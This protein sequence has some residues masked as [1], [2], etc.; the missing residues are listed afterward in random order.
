MLAALVGVAVAAAVLLS[1]TPSPAQSVGG[2][3]G[4]GGAGADSAGGGGGGDGQAGNP[5]SM[6]GGGGAPGTRGGG[7]GGGGGPGG[8]AGGNGG[9]VN[10]APPTFTVCAV[11]G[12]TAGNGGSSGTSGSGGGGGGGGNGGANGQSTAG[13]LNNGS[14]IAGANGSDGGVGGDGDVTGDGGGGGGGG[15]GGHG[16]VVTGASDNSNS[17]D[18]SG[19][20]G[21]KGGDGGGD[22]DVDSRGGNGGNGGD[23]GDGVEFTA[24]GASLTNSG[25][26][27]GGA[28]GNGGN[29]GGTA[30]AAD[31]YGGNGGKGGNGGSGVSFTASGGTLTNS[32]VVEG[33][34]GGNGGNGGA[35]TFQSG[36]GGNGGNGGAGAS[37]IESGGTLTNNGGTITGGNGGSG[38][39][40]AAAPNL[41][42]NGGNGGNGGA[43]VAFTA[44]GGTLTNS[45][46]ITGGNGGA[47]GSGATS[48]M[49]V[50]ICNGTDGTVG[51]GGAG[52]SG[53]NLSVLDS[54][55]IVGGLSGDSSTRANAITF[56][57]GLNSLTLAPGYSIIGNVIGTGSDIFA[58]AGS[59]SATFD[60]ANIGPTAQY[61]GFS[62]FV[63]TGASVW[64]LT[65]STTA[66]TPWTINQGTLAV[67]A[68]DNLGDASGALSFGGG[69]LQFLAAFTTNRA[70]TLNAGGGTFDTDGNNDTLAGSITG[71]GGLTK[72]G[73]GILT[74]AG[75]SSYTG[76]TNVNAG[77]LQAAGANLL[78][79]MSAFTVAGGAT[80]DLN[81]FNQTIGSL[82]GAGAVTLG[83]ATL[84]NGGD[85]TSTTYAGA[86]SGSGG[87]TK[88]GT[89]TFVLTGTNGYT[90]ATNINAG[91]LEVDGAITSSSN[92]TVNAGG[93][94]TGTGTVDPST[95]TIASGATFI[96]GTAGTA[97]SSM[98]IAGNLVFQSG[99]TYVVYVNPTTSSFTNVTGTASLA[100][101]VNANFASGSYI[102]KVY[103]ILSAGS[104]T[105]TFGA[106]TTANLP[107]NFTASLNYDTAHAYLDLALSF[108]STTA[109]VYVANA[110]INYFNT[111]GG[112]P[113]KFGTL[114]GSGLT[115]VDGEAA[116]GAERGAFQMMDQ[117]LELI[118]DPF[119]DS[120]SGAGWP[121]GGGGQAMGFA[122]DQQATLPP[123]IAL[124]YAGVLKAPPKQQS[125][126]QRWSAW[127]AGFGGSNTTNGD[128]VVGSNTVTASDYGYA[129]GM[130]YHFSP[131]TVGGFA[132]AGGG[133]NW[134]LAQGLGGGRSDAFQAGVYG[135][136]RSGPLYLAGALAF[137]NNWMTTN[138]I[139]LGDQL[140]ASFNA[141]SYGGRLEAGYRY[142]VP[143][144]SLPSPASGGGLGWGL[145]GITPY[146][147][148]Q[149]QSF[150]TPSYSETDLTGG[151]FGLSY[152]AMSA[153]DTR[154]ELGARFD[155]PT[156]LGAMPLVLRA[157]V[158]WA[159]DWVSNPA[160][161]AVF[162]SLPGASFVVN[163]APVPK[164][165][166]LASVGAVLHMTA[167]L[168]FS[169]K[170]DGEF[171][172]NSQ[173]YAGSGT[174]RY[175]W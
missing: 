90:G 1:P 85:N 28:G 55:T 140:T 134:G 160:L 100:G 110:L 147:A 72:I 51:A 120:R 152:S 37:F 98:T 48:T 171:A 58:L 89:G 74:L 41:S 65:G 56:T 108:T 16:L 50:N 78:A 127:G 143:A 9:A 104:V 34:A 102:S 139:A 88:A 137:A 164:D 4:T 22:N 114:T 13:P 18:I 91:T 32:N 81:S 69:T 109:P 136:T 52:V 117:F 10:C 144:P 12:G 128:P 23:G 30:S 75:A 92:V 80:L 83:S 125:F 155:D 26:A 17:A 3:G 113:M 38:G 94:L 43:G 39:G 27:Q 163:G 158:A 25:T 99:S 61:Q 46:T 115:N 146:A 20:I 8:G 21:G 170:F 112:I 35:A 86:I 151:G 40:G 121:A 24:S 66:V 175:T 60:V 148:V 123:D 172:N 84:T 96:P 73:A 5:G 70:V 103:T 107:S 156:L 19:G 14:A 45:G 42:G 124:A 2:T 130:D 15:A 59:G 153:T 118:L 126:D 97:G 29:G 132:L 133:T 71:S 141:Q 116:T 53:A 122:P 11:S 7:G 159:H 62:T 168:S 82:A 174:L 166:A 169:A 49:C 101:A 36:N 154:S 76:A 142:A 6:G 167:N 145:I 33:G 150:H 64:T 67:S 79:P 119:V 106:L 57:G 131:D 105:G 149:V 54:G 129:A 95:V 161:D 165:S 44:S 157:R 138:R 135:V 162:E 93:A 63:K 77:A 31:T 68:D 87:L 47:A 173:T 111:T